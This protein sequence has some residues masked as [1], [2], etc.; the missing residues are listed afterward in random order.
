L[1][2]RRT[3]QTTS[4]GRDHGRERT[5]NERDRYTLRLL[6]VANP[7][8]ADDL[9]REVGGAGLDAVR[10]RLDRLLDVAGETAVS[11]RPDRAARRSSTPRGLRLVS[12]VGACLA[13]GAVALVALPEGKGRLSALDAAAAVAA[14]QPPPEA[15]AGSYGHLRMREGGRINP[16][17]AGLVTGPPTSTTEFWVGADGSGRILENTRAEVGET[18]V[19]DGWKRTG[20]TW[21]RD[22]RFGAGRFPAVYRRVTS[23]VLDLSLGALPT[24]AG[25][26]TALLQRKLASAAHDADP[27]TGFRDSHASPGEML[28]VIG[29]ILA[30]PLAPPELRSALYEVAGTLDHVGVEEHVQDPGG[31][32]ATVIRLNEPTKSGTRNRYELFFDPQTSAT[33]A[34]QFTTTEKLARG[35]LSRAP[36][37]APGQH[38][39][40]RSD[41]RPSGCGTPEH[42][43]PA[44]V[45]RIPR[46]DHDRYVRTT[47]TEFTIY[48]Q[49][50][51]VD[52]IHARP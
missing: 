17:P 7:V 35:G 40:E 43:C 52:S 10:A 48:D 41:S 42:P 3:D 37:P 36:V 12:A 24:D 51:S 30:H 4:N 20:E 44:Q 32:P 25:A 39:A 18:P 29:Q 50:D 47:F 31:R 11:P 14:S 1:P 8:S 34:T 49:R 5:M 22:L 45:I 33:L 26:L 15:A 9:Q 13:L 2:T 38:R 27:E 6:E 16:W 21:T 28:I 23:T 19:G 46:D